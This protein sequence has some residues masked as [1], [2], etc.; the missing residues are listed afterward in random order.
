M[1]VFRLGGKAKRLALALCGG[2]KDVDKPA[3]EPSSD[4]AQDDE[5]SAKAE[6]E[7]VD[8][9]AHESDQSLAECSP[10]DAVAPE[11][12][13]SLAER[14]PENVPIDEQDDGDDECTSEV[15]DDEMLKCE[16]LVEAATEGHIARVRQLIEHGASVYYTQDTGSTPRALFV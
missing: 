15:P 16:A 2:A 8:D 6:P 14:S 12:D 10:D 3:V 4:A 11:N 5:T 9:V 7:N 1:A 13:E